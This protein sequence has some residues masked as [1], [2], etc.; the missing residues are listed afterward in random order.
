MVDKFHVPFLFDPTM[1]IDF[2]NEDEFTDN[3]VTQLDD[4]EKQHTHKTNPL[5]LDPSQRD[6]AESNIHI[7]LIITAGPGSGKTRTMCARILY[8]MR[9]GIPSFKIL[10]LTFSRAACIEL[11]QRIA[12]LVSESDA[13]CLSIKV[14]VCMCD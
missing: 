14:R 12:R 7:P 3:F 1:Q 13:Q 6:A 5:R 9:K 8:L 2:D 10:T 4:L 11:R